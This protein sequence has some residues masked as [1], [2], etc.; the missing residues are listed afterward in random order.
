MNRFIVI[1]ILCG[2]ICTSCIRLVDDTTT[3]D[4]CQ[5]T[6]TFVPIGPPPPPDK[7][8]SKNDWVRELKQ[9]NPNK[10]SVSL[11]F[12]FDTIINNYE[13]SGIFYPRC[14]NIEELRNRSFDGYAV[15]YYF[16]NTLTD[17]TYTYTSYRETFSRGYE[18]DNL[19]RLQFMDN[20][21]NYH[22]GDA[23][24]FHYSLERWEA[25]DV[26]LPYP[27]YQF[28]DADFDGEDDLVISHIGT[29]PLG[30]TYYDIYKFTDNG[31]VCI[32]PVSDIQHGFGID[33]LT[34]FDPAKKTITC[35]HWGGADMYGKSVYKF[36][37]NGTLH[38][39]DYSEYEIWDDFG[40]KIEVKQT[41][42]YKL[43]IKLF[44]SR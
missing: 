13:V 43:L 42:I 2:I 28:Y 37:K 27:E 5:K 11:Y 34:R 41:W 4:S 19:R 17:K 38:F 39:I 12:K 10:D 25:N 24:L 23:Y 7:V 44:F 21:D 16:H 9:K 3:T 6:D 1:P 31:L 26:L 20:P 15:I 36:D 35:Y 32:A 30:A 33:H 14:C 29:G 40:Y 18:G 8:S 22:N